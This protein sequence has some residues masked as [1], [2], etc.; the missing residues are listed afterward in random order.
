MAFSYLVRMFPGHIGNIVRRA[1]NKTNAS[2]V[3]ALSREGAERLACVDR[4]G[5]GSFYR[6]HDRVVLDFT[7]KYWFSIQGKLIFYSK[8]L[9]FLIFFCKSMCD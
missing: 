3:L 9:S 8:G 2:V 4:K 5:F 6:L 7:R 1:W